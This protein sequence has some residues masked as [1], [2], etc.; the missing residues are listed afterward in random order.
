MIRLMVSGGETRLCLGSPFARCRLLVALAA[1]AC[2]SG[3]ADG[4]DAAVVDAS[5]PDAAAID[6]ALPD[7]T[8]S[9][10]SAA[11]AGETPT[12]LRVHIGPTTIDSWGFG[13]V[14]VGAD[15]SVMLSVT[16]DGP[17]TTG[18]LELSV[19]GMHAPQFT[20]DGAASDCD[21]GITLAAGSSCTLVLVFA[22]DSSGVKLASLDLAAS[23]GGDL[24][25][26]LMGAG[27]GVGTPLTFDPGTLDFG[28]VEAGTAVSQTISVL[29]PSAAPVT[30]AA[31]SVVGTG[32]SRTST[33][34]GAA[35]GAGTS[36][37]IV[38]QFAPAGLGVAAGMVVI[39]TADGD[40]TAA[41]SGTGGGRLTIVRAGAGS[42]VVTSSPPG[43][44]CGATCTG[45][46]A[47][48]VTLT[49]SPDA[50]SVFAGWDTACGAALVCNV[51]VSASPTTV[52]A[53][54]EPG[55]GTHTLTLQRI[56]HPGELSHVHDSTTFT[57]DDVCTVLVTAGTIVELYATTPG[58]FEGWSGGGCSGTGHACTVTVD[59]D[60]LVTATFAE[61][62][63]AFT[64]LTSF[65]AH[66]AVFDSA[67][68]LL[69]ANGSSVIKIDA[70]GAV[71]WEE[72]L[73]AAT[74][75]QVVGFDVDPSG[76]AF[77][78]VQA[79]GST[80]TDLV[81][82]KVA[83]TGG[84]QWMVDAGT[85]TTSESWTN[86]F[87]ATTPTGGVAVL[88]QEAGGAEVIVYDVDSVE[89]WRESSLPFGR[90]ID[91]DS[92]GDVLVAVEATDPDSSQVLRYSA[93]G[94]SGTGI[95]ELPGYYETYL[96][97]DT[98]DAIL[99]ST[100]GHGEVTVARNV[101]GGFETTYD[102][103]WS[104]YVEHAVAADGL[105]NTVALRA[106]RDDNVTGMVL[107]RLAPT[108]TESWSITKPAVQIGDHTT[109]ISFRDLAA[110]SDGRIAVVGVFRGYS[111][112][113]NWISIYPAP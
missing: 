44:D 61:D 41:L 46:F 104:A 27:L 7:A 89:Q 28:L 22:P 74:S 42:G 1:A 58:A 62:P 35:L 103:G 3:S 38:V 102:G 78:L 14:T 81:L 93:T 48:A 95:D 18:V 4:D 77:V 73:P 112:L 57:C 80:P 90:A 5:A 88:V 31:T 25:V 110:A 55:M 40:A 26:E 83:S 82:H 84:W 53:T 99:S 108:G 63:G 2:G 67:G 70:A 17:S 6:A 8:V 113:Y 54:F 49:A 20:V 23:P 66:A 96:D 30:I 51:P 59:A 94:I 50:L 100:S 71:V 105:G 15:A 97:V 33:T 29:N 37:D 111:E 92:A 60:T 13:N 43:I 36:C 11:D 16:N 10:A 65:E 64:L 87:L 21:G 9:D 86:D 91:V 39:T 75:P 72:V 109:G 12:W 52:T 85:R 56:G 106:I 101:V 19:V 69:V 79:G 98:T 47:G 34:C 24:S 68:N 32:F 107:Q 45:V 76:N